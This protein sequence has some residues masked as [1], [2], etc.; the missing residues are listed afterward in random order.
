MDDR[1]VAA[2]EP[3]DRPSAAGAQPAMTAADGYPVER[4]APRSDESADRT[5]QPAANW[6]GTGEQVVE[7]RAE[8]LVAHKDLRDLGVVEIQ[9]VVDEVPA[10]L[11]VDAYREEIEIEHVPVGLPAQERV[12]PW[13]EDGVLVVPVYEEQ[14]VLVKRLVVREHLRIRRV[15]TRE[16]RLFEDRVRR[17]RLI[18]DAP[19][20]QDVVHE[21]YPTD[22]ESDDDLA[23]RRAD[24][25]E[26]RRAPAGDTR[27]GFLDN[28]R[29]ALD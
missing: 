12:A 9:T 29:R 22:I 15:E 14:L 17:E 1:Y 16:R 18:V 5:E 23:P 27:G 28:I 21:R 13:E 4:P 19:D 20:G 7:L 24:T 10:R 11:E 6:T 2:D 8:E 25:D 3:E 26:P